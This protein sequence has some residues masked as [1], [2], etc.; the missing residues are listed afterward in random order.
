[1][2]EVSVEGGYKIM[3]R[4]TDALFVPAEGGDKQVACLPPTTNETSIGVFKS[5]DGRRE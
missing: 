3:R 5:R 1:M 2:C 4:Q